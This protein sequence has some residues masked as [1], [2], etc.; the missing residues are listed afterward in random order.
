M[1]TATEVRTLQDFAGGAWFD[2]AATE[3]LEDR[4][5]A[6]GDLS[7]LVPLSV[8]ADVDRAVKAAREAQPAWRTSPPCAR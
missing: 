1:S 3:T 5:P 4:D 8:A 6:T 7:A 2:S